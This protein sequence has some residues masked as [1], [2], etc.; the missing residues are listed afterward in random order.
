M[1][2]ARIRYLLH[3]STCLWVTPEAWFRARIGACYTQMGE[4]D[5]A[6]WEA[7]FTASSDPCFLIRVGE[8]GAFTLTRVNDAW[9]C[10]TGIPRTT[11]LGKQAREYLPRAVAEHAEAHMLEAIALWAPS[12]F[13][14]QLT[15]PIGQRVWRTRLVPW[16]VGTA[17]YLVGFARD[18]TERVAADERRNA[19]ESKL[20]D[21]QKLESLGILA[22][23]IAHD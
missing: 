8:S 11:V 14:E 13:E 9:E 16:K 18:V 2:S 6:T 17:D 21:A 15:F 10:A 4:P 20:L 1:I 12:E 5:L 22:G 3:L 23:G 19:L 7:F